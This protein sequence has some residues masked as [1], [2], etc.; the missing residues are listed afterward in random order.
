MVQS[1]TSKNGQVCTSELEL[2]LCALCCG[3][4]HSKLHKGVL[5]ETSEEFL[6]EL[7]LCLCKTMGEPRSC[8]YL[9][10]HILIAVQRRNVAVVLGLSPWGG[11]SW[12][13]GS[14]FR[15]FRHLHDMSLFIEMFLV[16]LL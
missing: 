16:H 9:L 8:E 6:V 2:L 7:G 5:G 10:Q 1:Q 13:A 4:D 12:T 14:H 11:H 15:M 3:D